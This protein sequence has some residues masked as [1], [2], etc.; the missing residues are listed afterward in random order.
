MSTY[1][2]ERSIVDVIKW[3]EKRTLEM[4]C[5][6]LAVKM[7]TRIHHFKVGAFNFNKNYSLKC[8]TN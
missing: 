2:N 4:M 7:M 6:L 1:R 3:K 8:R 5:T